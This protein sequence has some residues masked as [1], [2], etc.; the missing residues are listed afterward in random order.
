MQTHKGVLFL[1]LRTFSAT[2]GIEKVCKVLC[3][4][5]SELNK[6][7]SLYP[8]LSILSMYDAQNDVDDKYLHPSFFTG[9]AEKKLAFANAAISKG[10]RAGVVIVSHINLLSI[11]FL[12]KLVSPKTR[13]I[14]FAHGIEVWAPVKALHRLMLKKCDLFLTV[15]QF[16]KNRMMELHGIPEEKLF[17]MNNCIDPY[18]PPPVDPTADNP[19]RKK[20]GLAKQD[21]VLMTLSRLSSK[22]MYKGYDNVLF[23]MSRLKSRHPGIKY[24]LI[25]RYDEQEKK[26]LD[27]IIQQL[28]LGSNVVF[29]GYVEDKDLASHY[30][31][32]NLYVMPSKKE[33]FGIVFIEDMYYGLPVIAGNKDGSADALCN[34][35]LGLLVDP[36]N[37]QEIEDGIEKII[38]HPGESTSCG[39]K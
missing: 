26:R 29:T 31:L 36:D 22:E 7:D 39:Q 38:A 21:T 25:G 28:S 34:G 37:Q 20:Y 4:V 2:G 30:N 33:G 5:L 13:L 16:T 23:A 3:K 8:E 35:R 10:R 27:H 12:I 14:V 17:V 6:T 19:F 9:F 24:L 15:S 11:G 1:T 32:A 18:L